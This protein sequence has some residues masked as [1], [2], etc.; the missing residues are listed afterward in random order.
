M[1]DAYSQLIRKKTIAYLD[2]ISAKF[3]HTYIGFQS[4]VRTHTIIE[5][6]FERGIKV[7]VPI[8]RGQG[9]ERHMSHSLLND[10]D[11]LR[12]GKFEVPEPEDIHGVEITG[13]DAV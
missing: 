8:L 10:L 9:N 6:L 5:D 13:L 11:H 3:V 12:P 1:R 7:A 2:S 4:E